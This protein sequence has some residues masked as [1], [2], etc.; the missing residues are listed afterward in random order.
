MGN[1][2]DEIVLANLL[3]GDFQPGDKVIIVS[4]P[5]HQDEFLYNV[6]DIGT[7]IGVVSDR[8]STKWA[9]ISFSNQHT[10]LNS[11]PFK[12]WIPSARL[13]YHYGDQDV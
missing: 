8:E 3:R 12:M 10:N 4:S 11:A 13:A 1:N 5:V 2:M 6:G 9:R 7:V